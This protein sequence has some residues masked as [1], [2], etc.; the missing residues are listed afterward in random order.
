[1]VLL[2]KPVKS[3]NYEVAYSYVKVKLCPKSAIGQNKK[4]FNFLKALFILL[5]VRKVPIGS[6]I[7]HIQF[8]IAWFL[9]LQIELI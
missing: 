3:K 2:A 9:G 5:Q 8:I 7:R 6:N 1:M 4:A